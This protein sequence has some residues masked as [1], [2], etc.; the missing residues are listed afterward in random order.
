M[1]IG[2]VGEDYDVREVVIGHLDLRSK[3][4]E[5]TKPASMKQE[6]GMLIP[7]VIY[8]NSRYNTQVVIV[9]VSRL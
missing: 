3:I 9:P 5:F 8:D 1:A 7:P 2:L 4:R 6:C